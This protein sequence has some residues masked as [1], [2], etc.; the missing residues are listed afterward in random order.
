MAGGCIR[1]LVAVTAA[2]LTVEFA[3]A[4]TAP[5]SV[6]EATLTFASA[7]EPLPGA[8]PAA[9]LTVLLRAQVAAG[10]SGVSDP[11]PGT[12]RFYAPPPNPSPGGGSLGSDLPPPPRGRRPGVGLPR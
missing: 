9:D 11:G 10:P 3:D 7:D 12:P 1:F 5:E 2:N 6:Y 8:A 4:G